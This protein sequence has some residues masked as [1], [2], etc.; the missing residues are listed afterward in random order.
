[1][2]SSRPQIL[3]LGFYIKQL[4][5]LRKSLLEYRK[6]AISAPGLNKELGV[7]YIKLLRRSRDLRKE[8]FTISD[9]ISFGL[10][11]P[12]FEGK[13][14]PTF[15]SRNKFSLLQEKFNPKDMYPLTEDKIIFY[16]Y[17]EAA[18]LPIP[19][20]F[21]FYYKGKGLTI[22]N[23]KT[24]FE[25]ND[26][27]DYLRSLD[28]DLIIKPAFGVYGR[29][30]YG[31]LKKGNEYYTGDGSAISLQ[32]ALSKFLYNNPFSELVIQ[33]R[34]KGH[35]QLQELSSTENLQ[36]YRIATLINEKS[37]IE[38]L[39]AHIKIIAGYNLIDN[40]DKGNTGNFLGYIDPERG[41]IFEGKV[42][43]RKGLGAISIDN[44]PLSGKKLAGFKL[45]M[46]DEAVELVKKAAPLFSPIRTIG[47]DIG[48]SD[49]GI[50][51]IEGNM[52][53]DPVY[54]NG[55]FPAALNMLKQ[56]R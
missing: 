50:F 17:C 35:P 45:P 31:I 4:E 25:E 33:Q 38:I 3:R 53:W 24:L 49:E 6:L 20:V 23:G 27:A 9:A 40:N 19:K 28:R 32:D 22:Q 26:I 11:N 16:K 15:I 47:W 14:Y 37:E 29:G 46:W 2:I 30:I 39:L 8:K 34:L 10:Y 55:K 51:I 5:K 13:E 7:G 44:H 12:Q 48:V 56:Q 43:T 52:F 36:T 41:E 54:F 42:T 18:G 21:G 1:M